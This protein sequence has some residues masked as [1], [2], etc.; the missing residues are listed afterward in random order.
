M[1]LRLFSNLVPK[2]C[3]S[4]RRFLSQSTAQTE[5]IVIVTGGAKGIGKG[6]VQSF[7]AEPLHRVICLDVDIK[8]GTE[9]SKSTDNVDFVEA[10]VA[11]MQ[12]CKAAVESVL[13][14]HGRIDVLVNNAG[15]QPFNSCV[16]LHELDDSLWTKIIG[17]NLNSIFN[18]SKHVLPIMMEQHRLGTGTSEK[19]RSC[20]GIIINMASVQGLQSQKGVPAYAASK[21]A[22]LSLTRQ[23]AMDYGAYGIRVL[24]I[25]PGTIKTPLVDELLALGGSD[26]DAASAVYPLQSRCGEISEIGDVAVFMASEK[27]SFMHGVDITVDG[28][29]TSKGGWAT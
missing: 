13:E 25:N 14:K 27:A 1:A 10:D 17:V 6:I 18:M 11:C 2:A 8:S 15:I 22:A 28:G 3:G 29:I 4:M 5:R 7:A 9:L 20:G 16:A 12:S 19:L 26:Y 21:G 24:A 23:M